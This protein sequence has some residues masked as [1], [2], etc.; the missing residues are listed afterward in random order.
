M[1]LFR[2]RT[3]LSKKELSRGR[4]TGYLDTGIPE[5]PEE[6]LAEVKRR[7]KKAGWGFYTR[8]D[9]YNGR[10]YSITLRR[11]IGLS[12]NWESYSTI[13]KASILWHELVHIR[14]RQRM[15][16]S[17]FVWLWLMTP[18]GRWSLETPAYRQSIIAYETMSSG[19]FNGTEY[20]KNKVPSMRK[21]YKLGRINNKQYTDETTAIWH[22][23]RMKA[24]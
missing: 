4:S 10:K 2:R 1:S 23:A 8:K 6:S 3:K 22:S 5:D 14:Q 13:Q 18:F 24:A 7:I 20:T 12:A 17:R 9:T 11:R 21:G 15:G 19:A 16:H